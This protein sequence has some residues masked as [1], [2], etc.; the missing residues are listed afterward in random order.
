M[1]SKRDNPDQS[2]RS[3]FKDNGVRST[4]SRDH[5]ASSD[6]ESRSMNKSVERPRGRGKPP[7]SA[8]KNGSSYSATR[9]RQASPSFSKSRRQ[10][11]DTDDES[12]GRFSGSKERSR[13]RNDRSPTS[14]ASR[15]FREGDL[16]DVETRRGRGPVESGKVVRKKL[17]GRY[18]VRL[19]SGGFESEVEEE[20]IKKAKKAI[21]LRA[22]SRSRS[23]KQSPRRSLSPPS[24]PRAR[25][26]SRSRSISRSPIVDRNSRSPYSRSITRSR[27]R[28]S[29]PGRRR[30][31][32]ASSPKQRRKPSVGDRIQAQYRGRGKYYAGKITRDRHDGTFD[33]TYEDGDSETRVK[34]EWIR[35][36]D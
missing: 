6:D 8:R 34:E 4:R 9:F 35:L 20:Y 19:D 27:S 25:S 7:L 29:S 32:R 24:R 12:G 5:Y 30:Y 14:S 17:N 1:P 16:V 23:P 18:E 10:P 13:E 36:V 3:V 33:I 31:S 15:H 2:S 28:S 21:R 26:R 11:D 22:R